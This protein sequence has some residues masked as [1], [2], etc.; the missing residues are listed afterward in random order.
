[1]RI[2]R[3]QGGYAYLAAGWAKY[4]LMNPINLL[5]FDRFKIEFNKA[6]KAAALIIDDNLSFN[7]GFDKEKGVKTNLETPKEEKIS[8]F[9]A[10]VRPFADPASPLYFKKISC[11]IVESVG[12]K[13]QLDKDNLEQAVKRIEN[14]PIGL[15]IGNDNFSA[16]D[17]FL[18]YSKGEYFEEDREAAEILS[19]F[20]RI[21]IISQLTFFQFY[22]YS[23][24]VFKFCEY[25]YFLI[26]Q[27][28]KTFP[29]KTVPLRGDDS[30]CLYCK[31]KEGTF[32]CPEHVYPESLG[33]T[34]IILPKGIVCDSCNNGVL[35]RLD[36]HLVEHDVISFLK[37]M[38]LPINPKTGKFPKA[39]YQNLTIEKTH[40]RKI[41]IIA[42]SGSK[43]TFIDKS[44][45]DEAK[46]TINT[47]G[48]RPF[49]PVHLARSLYKIA[50]GLICFKN[51][52]ELAL[53]ERYDL[54][55]NFVIGKVKTFPNNLLLTEK[56]EPSPYVGG[57]HYL[58]QPSGTLF[59]VKIFGITFL[60]N[61]EA[62]PKIEMN[63]QL[64][65]MNLKCFSL[66]KLTSK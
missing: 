1:M 65:A 28:E 10:C 46:F 55:R 36:T 40:P 13:L 58:L 41:R 22:S 20:K 54:A 5:T 52:P 8:R 17:I 2:Y 31:K 62:N 53:H 21:P 37:V 16:L 49:N 48:C 43:K 24:D 32:S 39:K 7:F 14:G 9:A 56:C 51:G 25:L 11:L 19:A 15:A 30:V 45:N 6:K 59:I 63:N 18:A 26:R 44:T 3:A 12:I 23:Y 42:Q 64:S 61:L 66:E 50:L 4:N 33:N 29:L 35:S 57:S 47:I 34:E 38:F 60:F 27:I